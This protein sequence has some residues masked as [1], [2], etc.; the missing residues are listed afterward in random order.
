MAH[1]D[2]VANSYGIEFKRHPP[3][4]AHLFF[5]NFAQFLKMSMTRDKLVIG[6][7]YTDKGFSEV[8]V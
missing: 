1:S 2:T 4:F 8:I 7:A 3:G 6:V 5:C